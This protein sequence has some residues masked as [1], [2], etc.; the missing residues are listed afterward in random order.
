M[1]IFAATKVSLVNIN[2]NIMMQ[3]PGKLSHANI[4]PKKKVFKTD[5]NKWNHSIIFWSFYFFFQMLI[6]AAEGL[7][8]FFMSKCAKLLHFTLLRNFF[9][10]KFHT[11]KFE[12]L[13]TILKDSKKDS[14][15]KNLNVALA[16]FVEPE[17]I[18][19]LS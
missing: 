11:F 8:H 15:T 12:Q 18:R 10:N 16:L 9:K 5:W 1:W 13:I 17:Q 7:V 3:Q 2:F 4:G 14:V 19:R 6:F